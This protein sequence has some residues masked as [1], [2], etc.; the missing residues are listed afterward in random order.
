MAGL[1]AGLYCKP[2]ADR[3]CDIATRLAESESEFCSA[4]GLWGRLAVAPEMSDAYNAARLSRLVIF[5]CR[6]NSL[7][8]WS[9][10]GEH[11]RASIPRPKAIGIAVA[12]LI[13]LAIPTALFWM[14]WPES[15]IPFVSGAMIESLSRA[16]FGL[17]AFRFVGACQV[18]EVV[19]SFRRGELGKFVMVAVS[20]GVFFA[21][22]KSGRPEAVFAGYFVAWMLGT[23]ISMRAIR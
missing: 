4:S 2:Y 3:L 7:P 13:A 19:G 11:K 10:M 21:L 16:Y 9:E 23:V 5:A 15:L 22:D 6:S 17:Y 14:V 20:F 18:Q 12:Q 8:V 1:S